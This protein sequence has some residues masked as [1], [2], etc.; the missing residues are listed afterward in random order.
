MCSC[1]DH[2]APQFHSPS[3]LICE[4]YFWSATTTARATRILAR[5]TKFICIDNFASGGCDGSEEAKAR[6]LVFIPAHMD[7]VSSQGVLGHT[8]HV[9]LLLNVQERI[10]LNVQGNVCSKL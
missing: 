2:A 4:Q 8:W 10:S 6:K 5:R 7:A 9:T 3:R 1:V